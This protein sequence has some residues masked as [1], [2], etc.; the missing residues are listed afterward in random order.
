MQCISIAPSALI[1]VYNNTSL[2]R[3]HY[4]GTMHYRVAQV[5]YRTFSIS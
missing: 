1:S 3:A 4:Y 5:S 2:G